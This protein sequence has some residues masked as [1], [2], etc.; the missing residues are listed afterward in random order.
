MSYA[1]PATPPNSAPTSPRS[2]QTLE[3]T[4]G[5]EV[6]VVVRLGERQMLVSEVV[7]WLPGSIIELAKNSDS[8]L[9][10][11]INNKPIGC[12]SAVKV[13]ENFGLRINF[14]GDLRTKI[15]AMGEDQ[16]AGSGG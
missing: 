6:P 15:L 11:L 1:S 2:V 13:G 4:L 12:G 16:K 9:D 5:L 3:Q 10:L 7:G 8:E 14:V